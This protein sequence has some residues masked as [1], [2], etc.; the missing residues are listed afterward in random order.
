MT[1]QKLE[2]G[3]IDVTDA[4]AASKIYSNVLDSVRLELDY[5][6]MLDKKDEIEFMEQPKAIEAIP[7]E[8]LHLLETKFNSGK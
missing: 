5:Q 1:I 3:N 6:K 4:V 8:K 7:Q 2:Q